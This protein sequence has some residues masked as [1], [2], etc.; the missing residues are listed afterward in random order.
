MVEKLQCQLASIKNIEEYA[1]NA[2][3][4]PFFVLFTRCANFSPHSS[5]LLYL[6]HNRLDAHRIFGAQLYEC[7][8]IAHRVCYYGLNNTF[9]HHAVRQQLLVEFIR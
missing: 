6:M 9:S 2:L 5:P 1:L 3:S 4:V 7:Q 8:S